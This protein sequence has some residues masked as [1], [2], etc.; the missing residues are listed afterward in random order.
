MTKGNLSIQLLGTSSDFERYVMKT[1][2]AQMDKAVNKSIPIIEARAKPAINLAISECEE[3]KSLQGGDLMGQ[4]GLTAST[5]KNAVDNI[6]EAVSESISFTNTRA[7]T[8]KGVGGLEVHFQPTSFSNILSLS[9][10]SYS[11]SK[12]ASL[13]GQIISGKVEIDWLSWLLTK[14]DSIIV[15]GFHYEP[16]LGKGRSGKGS[17]REKGSWRVSPTHAGTGDDNF[18]TR[19]LQSKETVKAISSVIQK[20]IEKNWG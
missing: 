1:I 7:K 19:A 8:K 2:E 18:I 13:W 14:G 6:A 20:A 12:K 17:M 9:D 16:K 11:Y 4:L 15:S 10:S 5:A 3:M